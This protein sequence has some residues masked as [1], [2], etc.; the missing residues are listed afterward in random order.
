MFDI[1]KY[2]TENVDSQHKRALNEAGTISNNEK[3]LLSVIKLIA[4]IRMTQ[5]QREE[6]YKILRAVRKTSVK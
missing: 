6:I 3:K 4:S 5:G 2:I 1:T